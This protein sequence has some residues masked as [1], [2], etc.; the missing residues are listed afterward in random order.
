MVKGKA[1]NV[2]NN[3]QMIWVTIRT[4]LFVWTE[5]LNIFSVTVYLLAFFIMLIRY[6]K[7]ILR[8]Q[9]HFNH[10][11]WQTCLCASLADDFLW[12]RS[13]FPNPGMTMFQAR[14]VV[15]SCESVCVCVRVHVTHQGVAAGPL[16]LACLS[17]YAWQADKMRSLCF[18]WSHQPVASEAKV[19]LIFLFKKMRGLSIHLLDVI[20]KHL[21]RV[22][23]GDQVLNALL[24]QRLQGYSYN[25]TSCGWCD[26]QLSWFRRFGLFRWLS[27]A[28]KKKKKKP[29]NL[30]IIALDTTFLSH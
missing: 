11:T 17:S 13:S 16:L 26:L 6:Q 8:L 9:V 28:K 20:I 19:E 22:H 7:N 12:G 27:N 21:F 23:L 3:T 10:F 18:L 1:A 15:P 2:K 30:L 29:H 24:I 4:M 5:C 25:E 14:S